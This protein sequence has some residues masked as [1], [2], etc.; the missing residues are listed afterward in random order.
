MYILV[1][2]VASVLPLG[3]SEVTQTQKWTEGLYSL[4]QIGGLV[5]PNSGRS[6]VQRKPAA[7]KAAD[8]SFRLFWDSDHAST[9]SLIYGEGFSS[10]N[11]S[12]VSDQKL[13]TA[14]SSMSE[15]DVSGASLSNDGEYML[16]WAKG[17]NL[18]LAVFDASDSKI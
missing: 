10:S 16:V 15:T 13:M 2:V 12:S 1:T 17:P 7:L 18:T 14:Q 6:K 9:A 5:T 11:G 3:S 4:Y 8:N